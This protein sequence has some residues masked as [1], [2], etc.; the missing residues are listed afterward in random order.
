MPGADDLPDRQVRDRRDCVRVEV[1][2]GRAFPC[3]QH[4]DIP[5]VEADQFTDPGR[6]IDMRM[7]LSR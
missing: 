3:A 2:C 4:G 1:Q 6:A 7:T 5:Q